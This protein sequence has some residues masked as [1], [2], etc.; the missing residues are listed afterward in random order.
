MSYEFDSVLFLSRYCLEFKWGWN[1]SVLYSPMRV[2]II[3]A[4]YLQRTVKHFIFARLKFRESRIP[5]IREH[6]IF[7]NREP[8]ELSKTFYGL[9]NWQKMQ[10]ICE[11]LIFAK[12][13]DSRICAKIKCLRKFGVLQYLKSVLH[14]HWTD[15]QCTRN[16]V[17]RA[18]LSFEVQGSMF[19]SAVKYIL[20]C[21][22]IALQTDM[23]CMSF[24]QQGCLL[25]KL[26]R[27][28]AIGAGDFSYMCKVGSISLVNVRRF[29]N[30][31]TT[32]LPKGFVWCLT[33]MK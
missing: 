22:G 26:N 19:W 14:V 2:C 4:V 24:F 5:A 31:L 9:K 27:P 8:S 17:L 12:S 25:K 21:T 32:F 30:F 3:T 33:V 7:A 16:Y 18:E 10:K 6:L 13:A 28:S 11:H 20:R 29:A 1:D 23:G 15:L